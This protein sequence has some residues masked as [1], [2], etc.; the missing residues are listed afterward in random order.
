MVPGGG[1]DYRMWK[2]GQYPDFLQKDLRLKKCHF[3][4][5]G[6]MLENY[7]VR[8]MWVTLHRSVTKNML[9]GQG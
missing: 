5:I 9:L 6:K 3:A 7:E 4:P 1:V 8:G 2:N